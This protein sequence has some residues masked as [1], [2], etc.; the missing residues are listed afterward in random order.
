MIYRRSAL[1]VA[2]LIGLLAAG[3]LY[4]VLSERRLRGEVPGSG[5][6]LSLA[7]TVE[8]FFVAT[9]DGIFESPNGIDWKRHEIT[10][11]AQVASSEDAVFAV[12]GRNLYRLDKNAS[13]GSFF[14]APSALAA[15]GGAA[16]AVVDG[17]ISNPEGVVQMQGP[18]P[19]DVIAL[20]VDPPIV[21]AGGISSGL[22]K[23]DDRGQT[24]RQILETPTSAVLI[25]SNRILVGTPGGL[26][27]SEAADRLEFT[28]LREPIGGITRLNGNFY[29]VGSRLIYR[30]ENGKTG[31]KALIL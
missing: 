23:S 16:Y 12:S 5:A 27:I 2:L 22:W 10:T 31:W 3:A 11:L 1:L 15:A 25:D 17:F 30:S 18:Q 13:A 7:A 9:S 8:G 28:D 29:A 20:D 6:I 21:Y 4:A 26:L 14:R 19:K 24:W